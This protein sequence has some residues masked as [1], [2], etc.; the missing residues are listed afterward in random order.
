MHY[1]KDDSLENSAYQ[2]AE[3][4]VYQA[5]E[6]SVYWEVLL[7][8]TGETIVSSHQIFQQVQC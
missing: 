5:A 7:L 6:K 3:R 1:P 2:A 8:P 4:S